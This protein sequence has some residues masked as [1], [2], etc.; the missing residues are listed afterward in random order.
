MPQ[1]EAGATGIPVMAT[2]YSGMKDV[3][4]KL[5]G[6]AIKPA[7]MARTVEEDAFKA[8]PDPN[9]F[10][11]MLFDFFSMSPSERTEKGLKT[12]EAVS[13]HYTWDHTANIWADYFQKTKLTGLQGQWDSPP[14][15]LRPTS[16]GTNIPENL[17]NAAFVEWAMVHVLGDPSFINSLMY[18]DMVKALNYE[19][20]ITVNNA[21]MPYNRNLVIEKL[22]GLVANQNSS[23]TVRC[24]NNPLP[25]E[26]FIE[27][28]HKTDRDSY[29]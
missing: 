18:L 1:V 3:M 10:A 28:A 2:D 11:K 25:Q 26:D 22:K 13:K 20:L 27:Y 9:H 16:D 21:P 14:K 15:L 29:R 17:S 8:I 12:R 5:N 23:E 7:A 4:K 24:S 19:A 6:Y